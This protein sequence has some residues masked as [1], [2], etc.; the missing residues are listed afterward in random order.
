[1]SFFQSAALLAAAGLLACLLGGA[2][3]Q[4]LPVFTGTK[5]CSLAPDYTARFFETDGGNY[6]L[7]LGPG[8]AEIVG[9]KTWGALPPVTASRFWESYDRQQNF[10]ETIQRITVHH[11]HSAYSIQWL[12]RRHQH[13]R[14][15]PK[16]DVAYHFLIARDG[17]IYE[18]RPLGYIGSHSEADNLYNVGIALN[19]NFRRQPPS[20]A[21]MQALARLLE[22]LRCPCAPLQGAWTHQARKQL[23]FPGQPEKHTDCPGAQGSTAIRAL[24]H[25]LGLSPAAE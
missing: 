11:T 16:A 15:D 13:M 10:C 19:G 18:G 17:T 22:A 23:N 6:R 1:M 7:A 21:Q 5:V 9:R 8:Q 25:R 2:Q 24:F 12:Q 3:P 20:V 14:Q 4:A